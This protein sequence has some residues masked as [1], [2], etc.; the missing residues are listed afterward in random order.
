MRNIRVLAMLEAHS[1]TGSAKA[2]LEFAKEA[3]HGHSCL[4]K[5]ELSI[6]TFSRG[7]G[8]DSLTMAIRNLGVPHDIVAERGR[9]DRDII[10]QL[11][12]LVESRSADLIWSNSVKSHFL[13]RFAGLHRQC[14][15]V[16]YHHGYTTTDLKV[17]LYNELDRWSLR[18]ADRVVTVCRPFGGQLQRNGVQPNRI[19]IQQM[20]IRPFAPVSAEQ[21]AQLRNQLSLDPATRVL[22]AIGR[23]SEEK[24]YVELVRAFVRLREQKSLGPLRLVLVGEGPERARIEKLAQQFGLGDAVILTGQQDVVASYF[25][26]ADVFV[27]S[28]HTE[29]SPNV[30]LEAMAP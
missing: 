27:L 19:R 21:I 10:P 3:A 7:Q 12:S 16:A 26:I 8:E 11:V 24:G 22:L 20:P 5:V 14:A 9:F 18:A 28:S 23:L 30:L 13:V 1:I 29:G 15:W 6:V 25:A 4:P 17:R 2:V